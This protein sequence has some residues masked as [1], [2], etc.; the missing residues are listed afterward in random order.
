MTRAT[1]AMLDGKVSSAVAAGGVVAT[2]PGERQLDEGRQAFV[3]VADQGPRHTL[4]QPAA[5]RRSGI[6]GRP[7]HGREP[8]LNGLGRDEHGDAAFSQIQ[9]ELN[10]VACP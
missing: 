5:R 10:D 2:S 8:E 7:F 6:A 3:R 4:P 9:V 1:D